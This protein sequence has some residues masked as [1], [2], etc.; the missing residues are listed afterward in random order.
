MVSIVDTS[1]LLRSG[2]RI[3][4][5]QLVR[6]AVD[7]TGKTL[8]RTLNP[9]ILLSWNPISPVPTVPEAIRRPVMAFLGCFKGQPTEYVIRYGSGRVAREGQG[10]A[11]FHLKYNT[12][13]V[14]VPTSSMD[15]NLVFNRGR[16]SRDPPA[17]GG[18]G[19]LGPP[20]RGRRGGAEDQ[21]ERAGD[22]DRPGR[23]PP[24]L[25]RARAVHQQ[26]RGRRDHPWH[27]HGKS[28]PRDP[29]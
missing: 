4:Y 1:F 17:Q 13:V 11:F 6:F 24:R 16:V 15:A 25:H 10:L 18:H 5:R 3:F 8:P 7:S 14:V 28:A 22:R 26:D 2:P 29:L 23:A 9:G 20:R 19:D 21:G 27:D 12:Q